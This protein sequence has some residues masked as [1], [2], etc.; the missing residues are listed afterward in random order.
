MRNEVKECYREIVMAAL[1]LKLAANGTEKLPKAEK[2]T[3][4][5]ARPIL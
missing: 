3:A 2:S 4:Q 1:N 5:T